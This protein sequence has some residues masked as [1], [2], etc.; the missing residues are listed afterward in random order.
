MVFLNVV[1]LKKMDKIE[2][3]DI[4]SRIVDNEGNSE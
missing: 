2:F 3:E 4:S 1:I